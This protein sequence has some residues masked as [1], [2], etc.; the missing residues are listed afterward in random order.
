MKSLSLY[1]DKWYIVGAVIID[2]VVRTVNLPN[3]EDRIWLYFYEDVANDEISYGKGFQAKFRNKEPHYYGDVFSL[4]TQSDAKY[5]MFKLPQPMRG[6]FK[7]AKIFDDL[8][9]DFDEEEGYIPTYISF[10]S[11]ISMAA[12]YIF[13]EEMKEE[14]FDIRESVARIG[15]L[16]LEYAAKKLSLAGDG[17]YL[18]L[19]ACNEN[20]HY[21]LYQKSGTLFNRIKEAKLD[22]RGSD[23]RCRALIEHIVDNINSQE[24]LLKTK[25]EREYEYLRM[26]QF[27]D[28]WIVKLSAAKGAIPV[29]INNV[30]FSLDPYKEYSVLVR[31]SKIDDHTEK[32]VKDIIGEIARFTKEGG[33]CSGDVKG[34]IMIGDSFTN[35]QFREE[36]CSHFFL[37]NR[38]QCFKHADLSTLVSAYSF[39]D[40]NQFSVA[41]IEAKSASEAELLRIKNAE[42]ERKAM[43]LA[44]E[45]A[46]AMAASEKEATEAEHK[47]KEAIE[48]GYDAERDHDFDKMEEYFK[49]ALT[50]RP[51]DEE[52]KQKYEEA[53]RKKA[54]TSVKQTQYKNKIQQAKAALDE[55]DHE[56]AKSIAE[57]ALADMP[58]SREALRIKDEASRR[59]NSQKELERY[60][61]RADLFIAQ[62]A[63]DQAL[64]ELRMAQL[65]DVDGKEIA[66]RV[67][68]VRREQATV[69]DKISQL[70]RKLEAAQKE[71]LHDEALECC[72]ELIDIDFLNA[73][74]WS[75][76]KSDIIVERTRAA[77]LKRKLDK[78]AREIESCQWAEEWSRMVS[79]CEEYLEMKDDADIRTKLG[80][81]RNKLAEAEERKIFEQNIAEIKDL[82][83]SS[84]FKEARRR[85]SELDKAVTTPGHETMI[86]ELNALIFKKEEEAEKASRAAKRQPTKPDFDFGPG[87]S[88]R[89][90][91]KRAKDDD[92]FFGSSS[93]GKAKPSAPKS[94]PRQSGKTT[95]D[96]FDF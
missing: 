47:F 53:L 86:R 76:R 46:E 19:D 35:S 32:I 54:E 33:L 87:K 6:I 81:A 39:I 34:I 25:A 83:L 44:Q 75:A 77:E 93:Y 92:D 10:S 69:N 55:G 88:A 31:K 17:H 36:L 79:R 65:L 4:V 13:M 59:I 26:N 48:M 37:D 58:D 7:S 38:L 3:R 95:N 8:R 84:N 68:R 18:V 82:I 29:Q 89:Q 66:E 74:K 23:P 90:K 22:G 14:R 63:Y 43:R 40:C 1:V 41:T 56:A 62:K 80:R 61:V 94:T 73:R 57:A 70:L 30:T 52:A 85:L 15:H 5:V 60:L 28:D 2:G 91:A 12:R 24:H 42:E 20:I 9:R 64:E 51:E 50:L 71:G 21:A 45:K 72:E 27:V 11:D 16:A 49:I 67:E 78:I 96:D